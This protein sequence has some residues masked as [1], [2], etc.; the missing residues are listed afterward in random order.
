MKSDMKMNKIKAMQHQIVGNVE[1]VQDRTSRI[2]QEQE[3]DLLRAF[4]ARLY[5]VRTNRYINIL[6]CM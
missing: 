5:D 2:L 3:R 6:I 1:L 4:R